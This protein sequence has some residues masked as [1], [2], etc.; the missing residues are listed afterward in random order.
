MDEPP[1]R[2]RG[3]PPRPGG[4]KEPHTHRYDPATY[5]SAEKIAADR[6]EDVAE[7]LARALV[8]YVKRHG[9]APTTD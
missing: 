5:A 9:S 2:G 1:K 4:R 7:V 3:R 8:N 6:G